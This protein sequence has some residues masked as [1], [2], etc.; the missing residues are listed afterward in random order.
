MAARQKA[1][2]LVELLVVITILS[3]LSAL[4]LP[5]LKHALEMSRSTV[6]SNQLR[7]MNLG[8]MRYGD[9]FNDYLP[10]AVWPCVS[11]NILITGSAADQ[12]GSGYI[13]LRLVDCP[14]DQTRTAGVDFWNYWGG[15]TW[16]VNVSYVYNE[17]LVRNR[18]A[19]GGAYPYRFSSHQHQSD[20]VTLFH[21]CRDGGC[22]YHFSTGNAGSSV[23]FVS[24][25]HHPP[26]HNY[27]FMD[28]HIGFF[29]VSAYCNDL[30][31]RGDKYFSPNWGNVSVNYKP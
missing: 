20:N 24:E 25:I 9:D 23:D 28:G 4:L 8:L 5:T 26:G 30:R 16:K 1:F 3:I 14:S 12:Y 15:V 6:C 18:S 2:T 11:R 29:S 7:Q 21:F 22:N 17:A 10:Y 13:P 27:A 31:N 19:P